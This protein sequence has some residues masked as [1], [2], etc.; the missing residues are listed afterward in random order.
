MNGV[1][2]VD[3]E[4][5][6]DTPPDIVELAIVEVLDWTRVGRSY[7]WLLRP[8]APITKFVSRIHGLTDRDVIGAPPFS[9]IES[10]LRQLLKSAT[11]IAH[12][13]H[14]DANA[15]ARKLPGWEPVRILDTL[16]LARRLKPGLASYSLHK[17]CAALNIEHLGVG[18][19]GCAHSAAYDAAITAQL[20][21]RLAADHCQLGLDRILQLATIPQEREPQLPFDL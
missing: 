4:G 8:S 2:V 17:L 12:N 18:R 16:R 10:E 7:Y 21:F 6:G 9:T 1:Y 3:F 11:V 20:F 13:A 19:E 14:V 5:N 15:L